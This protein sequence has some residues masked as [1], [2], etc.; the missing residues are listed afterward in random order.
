[1]SESC[2]QLSADDNDALFTDA[3]FAE[4]EAFANSAALV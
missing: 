1:L 3:D 4:L 2:N